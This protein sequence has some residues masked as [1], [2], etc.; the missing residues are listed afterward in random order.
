M[1]MKKLLLA[2]VVTSA[3]FMALASASYAESNP[4]MKDSKYCREMSQDVIC[5]GPEMMAMRAKMM[6][7]TKEKAME[8]RSMYCRDGQA[9]DP[10]CE[11][12]MMK[13]T[14]GY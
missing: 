1:K 6:A 10:I 8:A 9:Q 14:T 2:C 5:M 12:K 13:D 7:M 3:G 11:E 4:M